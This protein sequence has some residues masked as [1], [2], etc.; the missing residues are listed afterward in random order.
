M[1]W[2]YRQAPLS[3]CMYMMGEASWRDTEV[4]VKDD[5]HAQKKKKKKKGKKGPKNQNYKK[6][7]EIIQMPCF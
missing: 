7:I 6:R 5:A 3:I 1:K 4:S 2:V